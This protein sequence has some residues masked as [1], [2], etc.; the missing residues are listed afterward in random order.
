MDVFFLVLRI[1]HVGGAMLWFGGAIL[2]I[3]FLE[4][5]AKALG[6]AAGPFMDHVMNRRR[7]GIFFPI[8]ALVTVVSGALLYWRD[9]AGLN[10]AWITSGPGIAFT[11]GGVAAIAAFVGGM[12]LIPPSVA[13]QTEIRNS[14]AT[15]GGSPSAEQRERLAWADRRLQLA[16]RI[17][18]PLLLVA[19]LTMAVARYM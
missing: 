17:D 19:G 1:A 5:A 4:P 7:M 12:I 15:S 8:V 16:T 9:S 6:P 10:M 13:A 3:L 2:S 18:L 11:V 14:L